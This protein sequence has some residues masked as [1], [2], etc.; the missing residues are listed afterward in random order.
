MA[1]EKNLETIL[2]I[3]TKIDT[4]LDKMDKRIGNIEKRY[5]VD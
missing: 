2:G 1:S 3:L 4:R 5:K